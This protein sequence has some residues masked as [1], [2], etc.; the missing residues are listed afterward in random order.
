MLHLGIIIPNF[1]LLLGGLFSGIPDN[2]V[3]HDLVV[4]HPGMKEAKE[5]QLIERKDADGRT[6]DFYMEV[7]SVICL[8]G[9][10]KEVT[11][12]INWD[13]SLIHI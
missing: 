3:I 7:G 11:V 6:I 2:D 10:C 4:F 12:G 5:C 9:L 13:L 1:L 8:N